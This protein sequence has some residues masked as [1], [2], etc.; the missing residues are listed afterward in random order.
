MNEPEHSGRSRSD[1]GADEL[2]GSAIDWAQREGAA[3]EV[4]DALHMLSLAR[5]ERRRRRVGTGCA[6]AGA[7]VLA[8]LAL[9]AVETVAFRRG[10]TLAADEA[11]RV[12]LITGEQDGSLLETEAAGHLAVSGPKQEHLPD[13]SLVTLRDGAEL[14]L[15]FSSSLRRVV[16]RKG[17]A[18]FAVAKDPMRAFEVV[19]DGVSIRALGTAFCV[20]LMQE[21]VEVIV[22]EGRVSVEEN[23]SASEGTAHSVVP[24]PEERR[25]VSL[26]LNAGERVLAAA[27]ALDAQ[28]QPVAARDWEEKLSWRV[29]RLKFSR[30]RLGELLPEFNR[31]SARRVVLAEP[32]LAELRISGV[33]RADRGAALLEMLRINFDLRFEDRGEAEVV[34][35]RR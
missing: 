26:T 14:A 29:P 34:V 30:V 7:F 10:K 33:L 20:D 3:D 4:L 6:I 31:Y 11:S 15:E 1:G 16:L 35:H 19:A 28:V 32:E 25:A 21:A 13:G 23:G 17:T 12:V 9:R 24:A 22:T 27:N 2:Q 8:F 18:Y 5:R